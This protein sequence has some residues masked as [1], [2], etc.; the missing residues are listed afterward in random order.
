MSG[1]QVNGETAPDAQTA[2]FKFAELFVKRKIPYATILGNHDDEGNLSR[3]D[4]MEITSA[5]PYSVSERGPQLGEKILDAKGR[6]GY[7]GGV[8]NYHIE[9]LAHKY[10]FQSAA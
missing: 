4:V 2:I 8:G 6:E 5:L 3:E 7:E 10:G 9:V 1:D